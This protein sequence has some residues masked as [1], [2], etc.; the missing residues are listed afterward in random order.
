ML[1]C[2]GVVKYLEFAFTCSNNLSKVASLGWNATKG[3]VDGARGASSQSSDESDVESSP[4]H[5][6]ALEGGVAVAICPW[7]QVIDSIQRPAFGEM[8]GGRAC[9]ATSSYSVVQDRCLGESSCAVPAS[10]DLFGEP[11]R[12]SEIAM[13]IVQYVGVLRPLWS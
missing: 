9:N 3:S 7:G 6:R 13:A 8:E 5:V 2:P 1:Q 11:V 4:K 12:P 10:T